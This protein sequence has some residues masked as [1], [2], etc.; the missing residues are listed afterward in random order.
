MTFFHF[1]W[2]KCHYIIN[3]KR[4]RKN[5]IFWEFTEGGLELFLFVKY[6]NSNPKIK[7]LPLSAVGPV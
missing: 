5:A 3:E 6:N 4:E 7:K 2:K 1:R